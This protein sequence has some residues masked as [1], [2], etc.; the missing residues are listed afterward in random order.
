MLRR[1]GW[2][3]LSYGAVQSCEITLLPSPR[4]AA[5]KNKY[6]AHTSLV[7]QV[8]STFYIAVDVLKHSFVE[9]I[10]YL[11]GMSDSLILE[12]FYCIF[13]AN[14]TDNQNKD[15]Q[16]PGRWHWFEAKNIEWQSS[17]IKRCRRSSLIFER[18]VISSNTFYWSLL[19]IS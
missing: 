15:V 17:L 8:G 2:G 10:F 11:I 3:T 18:Y 9:K 13:L 16:K 7:T 6:F 1:T 12:F 5:N 19:F 4:G 14:L